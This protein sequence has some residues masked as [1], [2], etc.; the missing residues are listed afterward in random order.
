VKRASLPAVAVAVASLVA[1]GS[2]GRTAD[3]VYALDEFRAKFEVAVPGSPAEVAAVMPKVSEEMEL[4][5]E[6]A[7]TPFLLYRG[8]RL[9]VGSLWYRV[10][11]LP[12]ADHPEH[13]RVRVFAVPV[14]EA[15]SDTDET[16]AK[17]G[18]LA[19]R[20]VAQVVRSKGAR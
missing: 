19:A 12:V 16:I 20:I 14:L 9:S 13:S 4:S 7:Q 1:C 3:N 2:G 10:D 15:H 8:I 17:P 6:R 5:I 18:E 11:V